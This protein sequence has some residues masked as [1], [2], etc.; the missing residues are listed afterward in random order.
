MYV[1]LFACT[2]YNKVDDGAVITN[3]VYSK[4]IV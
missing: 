1:K 4:Q 3:N 2:N